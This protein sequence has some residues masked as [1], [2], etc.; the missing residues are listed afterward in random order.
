MIWYRALDFIRTRNGQVLAFTLILAILFVFAARW[1]KS[2]Q[3]DEEEKG[4]RLPKLSPGEFWDEN[5]PESQ[6]ANKE[7]FEVTEINPSSRVFR[8]PPPRPV[9]SRQ[10][11]DLEVTPEPMVSQFV[12]RSPLIVFERSL[13]TMK[14]ND[15]AP[16]AGI[17]PRPSIQLESGRMLYCQ[18]VSPVC[19]GQ[20]NALV[21]LRLIRPHV[22]NGRI[23]LPKGTTL[24]GQ[25]NG[26]NGE[27][28]TFG[29]NWSA[30]LPSREAFEFG[31]QLQEAGFSMQFNRYLET[32]GMDGLAGIPS[33]DREE[34]SKWKGIGS[35][36]IGAAGRLAQD[37][38]RT[39]IGDIVPGSAR[40][41]AIG[42]STAVLDELIGQERTSPGRS[43]PILTVPAGTPCYILVMNAAKN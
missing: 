24:S 31:G 13:E 39:E 6:V 41:V 11:E 15:D 16:V 10:P 33:E 9:V 32:D 5:S 14:E 3:A 30:K 35:V 19:S 18:T 17:D 21:I 34:P 29:N 25:L 2:R 23:V 1:Q 27:R 26:S 43:R 12:P 4:S 38:V 22:E 42:G 36:L 40:N 28:L 37:R 8:I 20:G 7:D